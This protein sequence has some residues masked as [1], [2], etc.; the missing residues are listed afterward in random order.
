MD[1]ENGGNRKIFY[2]YFG[3]RV[4]RKREAKIYSKYLTA[5]DYYKVIQKSSIITSAARSHI[6]I[7][8]ELYDLKVQTIEARCKAVMIVLVIWKASKGEP[9]EIIRSSLLLCLVCSWC[10]NDFNVFYCPDRTAQ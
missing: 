10:R 6:K 5:K 1:R 4:L 7:I 9:V 3:S 8:E 2:I